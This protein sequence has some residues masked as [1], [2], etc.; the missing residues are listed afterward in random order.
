MKKK[1]H[2]ASFEALC[3]YA[4]P[5]QHRVYCPVVI[6]LSGRNDDR[7]PAKQTQAIF[8]GINLVGFVQDR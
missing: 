7:L 8:Q 2:P 1:G 3:L 4:E 5:E 6:S